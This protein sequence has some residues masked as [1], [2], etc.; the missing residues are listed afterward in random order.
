MPAESPVRMYALDDHRLPKR[1]ADKMTVDRDEAIAGLR[2]A[3]D[4]NN[5]KE[6]LGFI[7]G[8]EVAIA[9]CNEINEE[10]SGKQGR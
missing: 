6:R 10:L 9:T 4:W 2:F 8:L 5:F 3:M 1:L 7:R